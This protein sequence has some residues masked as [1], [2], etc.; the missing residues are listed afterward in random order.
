[1]D[2]AAH[3]AE[4]GELPR[5]FSTGTQ[6]FHAS[7]TWFGLQTGIGGEKTPGL[8]EVYE[9]TLSTG[10]LTLYGSIGLRPATCRHII[11]I[12]IN[13]LWRLRDGAMRLSGSSCLLLPARF[14]ISVGVIR[15]GIYRAAV[16]EIH[17]HY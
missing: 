17:L 8:W 12:N 16:H 1:V 7:Q 15:L 9:Q 13:I 6:L 2:W 14:N 11:W 10:R 4:R 5:V 3:L